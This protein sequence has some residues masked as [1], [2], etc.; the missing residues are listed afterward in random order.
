MYGSNSP[1]TFAHF[2]SVGAD[3]HGTADTI[4]TSGFPKV[5]ITIPADQSSFSNSVMVTAAASDA[6]GI[7][8]VEFYVDWTL[9]ATVTSAPY[10]AT[11]TPGASG[12][13]TV[14][15]MAYGNAGVRACYAVTLNEQ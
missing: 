14:A 1:S 7:S 8:K 5:A 4:Y 11:L 9:Q 12:P 6:S 3:V 13:H 2:Q 10:S 15:A